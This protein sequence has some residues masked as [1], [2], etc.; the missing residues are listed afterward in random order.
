MKDIFIRIE[1]FKQQYE[2]GNK[3]ELER[4]AFKQRMVWNEVCKW[5]KDKDKV[6]LKQK[7]LFNRTSN[8]I[9]EGY[10]EYDERNR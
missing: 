7:D 10:D 4:Y 8:Q 5:I 6:K 1:H 9:Q 2:S 3:E